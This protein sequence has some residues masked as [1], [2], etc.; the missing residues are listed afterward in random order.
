M[1][2][3][4]RFLR[5]ISIDTQ[6]DE[7]S[8]SHPSSEKQFDLARVLKDELIAL[9]AKNLRLDENCYLY[10]EIP[11]TVGCE[12]ATKIGFIA[13]MDTSPDFS[14]KNCK[15]QIIENY[16][17][18]DIALGESGRILSP[19]MFPSLTALKG[20]TLITTD[21][22]T[23]LGA[24]DKAGV[25]EIMTLAEALLT[26]DLPHG[27]VL[28]AFTP[29][30]EVGAGADLFD[31]TGFG[32]DFAYTVDGGAE[33]S[34]EYE[35][36]NAAAATFTVSGR[37]V[38]PGYAKDTMINAALVATEIAAM[39]PPDAI[40]AKTEGYEGFFHMTHIEGSCEKASVSYIVRDHDFDKFEAKK[41]LLKAVAA[42]VNAQYG[43]GTVTLTLKDSYRNMKEMILPC[44][45]LIENATK[46]AEA[47]GVTPTVEP[48][49]GGT[50]GA[51]L[52]YMGLPCPNLGTGGYAF[53]GPYEH[54]TKEGMEAATKILVEIV[55]LYSATNS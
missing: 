32:A 44:M 16:T 23:L 6:S 9:G 21:G 28:I 34:M 46:A 19:A 49:R 36:F 33:G 52:S 40:P 14:G 47:V 35:N 45:H 7:S 31:V 53:H 15:P 37:N 51:R 50:D 17:G 3:F 5:Y 10:A 18:G 20:R 39:L 1:T 29:D 2:V 8:A 30:E 55:K 4:E 41:E 26:T 12:N 43:E 27:K 13:H 25:A 54:T 48:I 38:H 11:A 42:S 24:D 22:T